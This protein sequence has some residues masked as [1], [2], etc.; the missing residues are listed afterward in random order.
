M[1][2]LQSAPSSGFR[3]DVVL[4]QRIAVMLFQYLVAGGRMRR[5]YRRK[6]ARGETF[7]VDAGGPTRH[8]EAPLRE[9]Q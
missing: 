3:R 2:T 7:W 4:L 8:R 5:E 9:K 6:E 1:R